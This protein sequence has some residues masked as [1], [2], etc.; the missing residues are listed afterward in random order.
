MIVRCCIQFLILLATTSA[1]AK[2][3]FSTDPKLL[4]PPV[5]KVWD[6]TFSFAVTSPTLSI[7]TAFLIHEEIE[8]GKLEL[9]FLTTDHNI[10]NCKVGEVCPHL[11]LMQDAIFQ[12]VGPTKTLYY[13][14]GALFE[15][16][17][18]EVHIPEAQLALLK[19]TVPVGTPVPEPVKLARHCEIKPRAKVFLIGWPTTSLRNKPS[20]ETIDR[21][22]LGL[23]RWSE[24][25]Y[26]ERYKFK[27]EAFPYETSTSD[28]LKGNSGGPFALEDGTV[29]SVLQD[30]VLVDGRAYTG[31]EDMNAKEPYH[32]AGTLCDFVE[33]IQKIIEK[34]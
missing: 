17:T 8:G 31:V 23:K 33:E 10:R 32:S 26:T 15:T 21:P 12:N 2:E 4:P 9:A 20:P 22:E 28:A 18:Y 16:V 30:V 7:G 3:G 34:N 25:I 27:G 1:I 29:I 14:K 6:A 13:P 11:S 19:V 24:G 5:Q